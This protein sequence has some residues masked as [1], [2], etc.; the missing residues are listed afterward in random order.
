MLHNCSNQTKRSSRNEHVG[1]QIFIITKYVWSHLMHNDK[2]KKIFNFQRSK[3][4]KK[5][6]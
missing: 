1:V 6:S 4:E 5:K 3:E 2:P